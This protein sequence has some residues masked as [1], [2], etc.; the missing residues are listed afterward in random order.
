[1]AI[2]NACDCIQ[3]AQHVLHSDSRHEIANTDECVCVAS[4]VCVCVCVCV[5]EEI[6]AA[7]RQHEK[8]KYAKQ[9]NILRGYAIGSNRPRAFGLAAGGYAITLI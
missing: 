2:P 4:D 1:M 7:H 6:F 9:D 8:K 3:S 5:I